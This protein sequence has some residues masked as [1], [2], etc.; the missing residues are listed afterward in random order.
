MGIDYDI[1]DRRKIAG[2]SNKLYLYDSFSYLYF[3]L[4]HFY[5]YLSNFWAYLC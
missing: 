1:S 5:H 4:I 3:L 2:R